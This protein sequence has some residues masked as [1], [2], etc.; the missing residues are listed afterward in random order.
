MTDKDWIDVGSYFYER[1]YGWGERDL[2]M[3]SN[4]QYAREC[5]MGMSLSESEYEFLDGHLYVKESSK[6]AEWARETIE[7][8]ENYPVL[9]DELL[10][11]LEDDYRLELCYDEA[12]DCAD[13][14]MNRD[15]DYRTKHDAQKEIAIYIADEMRECDYSA[16]EYPERE[17]V[18][19]G[20]RRFLWE[21]T[22]QNYKPRPFQSVV[23]S[24]LGDGYR[25]YIRD[26][27]RYTTNKV[28]SVLPQ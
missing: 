1:G 5:L 3:E 2:V 12:E 18:I 8:L 27:I 13:R 20:Y 15:N 19:R 21:W 14:F 23:E 11:E 24:M 25:A 17:L 7:E 16:M 6:A 10:Y 4:Y 22:N 28:Y 9:N 26:G